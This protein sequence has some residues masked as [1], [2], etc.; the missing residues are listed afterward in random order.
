MVHA[1]TASDPGVAYVAKHDRLIVTLVSLMVTGTPR[2]QR[3]AIAVLK[4]LLPVIPPARLSALL[5]ADSSFSEVVRTG[6]ILVLFMLLMAKSLVASIRRKEKSGAEPAPKDLAMDTILLRAGA[7]LWIVGRLDDAEVLEGVVSLFRFAKDECP[8]WG[9]DI[10]ALLE[11]SVL[12]LNSLQNLEPEAQLK[13]TALWFAL[14]S[15]KVIGETPDFVT[16]INESAR[17]AT[18]AA[19]KERGDVSESLFCDNH[20]DG[21][22]RAAVHCATCD[23]SFCGD[24]DRF[25]HMSKRTRDHARHAIIDDAAFA[26]DVHEGCARV[27]LSQ[28]LIVFDLRR[29]NALLR[30]ERTAASTLRACRFCGQELNASNEPL[31]A[32]MSPALENVCR[33]EMCQERAGRSCTKLLG[34]GHCCGGIRNERECM[35][36]LRGCGQGTEGV[37][38]LSQDDNDMCMICWT[39]PLSLAPSV[40]LD[41]GHVFHEECISRL[42]NAKW[43]GARITFGFLACPCCKKE[44]AHAGLDSILAPIRALRDKIREKALQR[45]S[46]MGMSAAEEVTSPD[47]EYHGNLEGYAMHRLCYYMCHKCQDPYFGGEYRCEAAGEGAAE[48]NPEELVCGGCS[49]VGGASSCPKHGQNFLEY[50]CRYCCSVAIWFCFGTTH[51]CDPCHNNISTVQSVSSSDEAPHCPVGP[52]CVQL[53]DGPCPVGLKDHSPPGQEV[54]LGCGICR[55]AATF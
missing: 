35:P 26:L 6:G 49:A 13:S 24:C 32:P 15:L 23:R 54:P 9:N 40:R 38:P 43:T 50:K 53:P 22:T 8:E 25:L 12:A 42:L 39:D 2:V 36:C 48:F 55:N 28:L 27:K 21:V 17:I 34:C 29:G 30:L 3:Q 33:D 11:S 18:D 47:G 52:K 7:P 16:R 41:C 37:L 45:A 31:T 4:R 46:Y 14:S 51:F 20:E 19:R 10:K 5:R 44:M 1:L